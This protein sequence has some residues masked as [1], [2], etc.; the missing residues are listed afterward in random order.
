[1]GK[2]RYSPNWIYD[3]CSLTPA[4]DFEVATGKNGFAPIFG[5]WVSW[6][7]IFRFLPHRLSSPLQRL[8]RW[9]SGPRAFQSLNIDFLVVAMK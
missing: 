3:P 4:G 5:V 6:T 9:V 8:L 2:P 7:I 1:M